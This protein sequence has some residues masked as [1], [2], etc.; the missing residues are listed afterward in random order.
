MILASPRL[1]LDQGVS[2]RAL[3]GI[4]GLLNNFLQVDALNDLTVDGNLRC[5]C[6]ISLTA[7]M[8]E[9]EAGQR[10][11]QQTENE[12]DIFFC[13][14]FSPAYLLMVNMF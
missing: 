7:K 4:A 12:H 8:D 11:D 5:G 9:G 6:L 1:Y 13:Q 14:C 2:Q 3:H 10:D